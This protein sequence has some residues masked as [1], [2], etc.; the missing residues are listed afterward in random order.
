[1]TDSESGALSVSS[2]YVWFKS[3][4]NQLVHPE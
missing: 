4:S 2:V 1:M 3:I